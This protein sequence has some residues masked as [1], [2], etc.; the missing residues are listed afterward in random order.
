MGISITP[1]RNRGIGIIKKHVDKFQSIVDGLDKGI[2]ICEDEMSAN[3]G[4]IKTL[5]DE[6]E[7]I[8]KSKSQA[9]A[10]KSNLESMLKVPDEEKKE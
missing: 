2:C 1:K 5:S 10:F 6:N 8:E 4:A 7:A 3:E 9:T